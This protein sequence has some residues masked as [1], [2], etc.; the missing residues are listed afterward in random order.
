MGWGVSLNTV[1][2]VPQ[3]KGGALFEY[4]AKNLP[5][6]P[7]HLVRILGLPFKATLRIEEALTHRSASHERGRKTPVPNYERLEFLGDRVIGLIVSEYLLN[8]WP[9]ASEGDIGQIFSGIVSTQT[10][11]SIARRMDLGAYMILGKGSHSSGDRENSSLLADTFES[12]AAAIYLE[13]GLETC[14]QVLIPWFTQPLIEI[15]QKIEHLREIKDTANGVV[16]T[17]VV[18]QVAPVRGGSLNYKL[19]LQKWCQSKMDELP[20][21]Q[22][23][24]EIGPAHQRRFRM[25]VF[26]KGKLLG[27]SEGTTKR[28]AS[29]HAAKN[30]WERIQSGLNFLDEEKQTCPDS[31][32]VSED[33]ELD[34][35]PEITQPENCLTRDERPEEKIHETVDRD[36]LELEEKKEE[37]ENSLSDNQQVEMKQNETPVETF[38]IEE[39]IIYSVP[40]GDNRKEEFG[41]Q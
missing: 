6:A 40:I 27:E 26:V 21:Y 34:R 20:A 25:G 2:A 18:A 23:L 24:E 29:V 22:V 35:H 38:R 9:S 8:T 16:S 28:G 4:R 1:E 19:L 41:G 15:V 14:R 17:V 37:R 11:A 3:P 36:P 10:L 5:R 12:L 7:E 13:Y 31:P 32:I 39:G 33:S 30:A